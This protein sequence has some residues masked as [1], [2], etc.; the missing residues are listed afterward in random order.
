M[1]NDVKRENNLFQQQELSSKFTRLKEEAQELHR[2][3]TLRRCLTRRG[4]VEEIVR[5]C[6]TLED[7]FRAYNDELEELRGV[8]DLAWD[9]QLQRVYAEQEV[10]Q[11]QVQKYIPK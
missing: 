11:S 9:D 1:C 2:D 10:F 7:Q 6:A 5:E 8:F 4:R 3:V